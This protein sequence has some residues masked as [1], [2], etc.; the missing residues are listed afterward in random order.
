MAM[1]NHWIFPACIT[2]VCW[3]VWSFIPKMTTR[4][5][6]PMSAIFYETIGAGIMGLIA[7]SLI[8]FKPDV[9]VKGIMCAVLT[10]IV[11]ISGALG[12][13]Y[14][15]RTG[16]VSVVSLFVAM[17]PIITIALA[18]YFLKEPITLKEGLGFLFA[19]L[20]IL[21]FT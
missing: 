2:L 21:C 20:A 15:I 1:T 19:L 3:G 14:A 12:F 6:S 11:G 16:K 18:F 4:F 17:S 13:L 7:L 10:G 9:H 8:G 5:I